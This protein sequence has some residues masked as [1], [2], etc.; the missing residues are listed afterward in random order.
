M[1]GRGGM[2]PYAALRG[3]I[4]DEVVNSAEHQGY[5]ARRER[6][7]QSLLVKLTGANRTLEAG[8]TEA[9]NTCEQ[10]IP[11]ASSSHRH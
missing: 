10:K 11:L 4:L 5:D 1:M 6:V 9:K 2:S 8:D 7:H 3:M